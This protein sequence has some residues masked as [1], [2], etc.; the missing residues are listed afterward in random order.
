MKKYGKVNVYN[1]LDK[2]S[3]SCYGYGWY[4]STGSNCFLSGS[5]LGSFFSNNVLPI[6]IGLGEIALDTLTGGLA[7]IIKIGKKIYDIAKISY[8]VM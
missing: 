8:E 1:Y 5:S 7:T 2:S 3:K 6:L 4:D